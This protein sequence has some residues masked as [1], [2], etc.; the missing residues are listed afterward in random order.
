MAGDKG[1]ASP[2]NNESADTTK[3]ARNVATPEIESQGQTTG[4][5]E[6]ELKLDCGICLQPLAVLLENGGPC[7]GPTLLIVGLAINNN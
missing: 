5:R 3:R 4:A 1:K 7:G 2:S 6:G